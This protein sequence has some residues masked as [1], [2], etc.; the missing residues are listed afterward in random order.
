MTRVDVGICEGA[1]GAS[2]MALEM[3]RGKRCE[4]RGMSVEQERTSEM[5]NE[6]KQKQND[7]RPNLR[8]SKCVCHK[9]QNKKK[10][11]R[12][13]PKQVKEAAAPSEF[14]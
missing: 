6:P 1:R 4:V 13:K 10:G 11:G 14:G 7:V 9:G 3:A 2:W 12:S 5:W 8:H